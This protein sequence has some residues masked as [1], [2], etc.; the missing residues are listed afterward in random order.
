MAST[1]GFLEISEF[2]T[3]NRNIASIFHLKPARFITQKQLN[4]PYFVK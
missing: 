4:L 1:N 3:R 2:F